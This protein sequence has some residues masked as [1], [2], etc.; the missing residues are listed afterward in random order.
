VVFEELVILKS[1]WGPDLYDMAA[2][3]AAQVELV[4][5]FDFADLLFEDV[6]CLAWD[7]ELEPAVIY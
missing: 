5:G 4:D 2:W 7:K 3:N 1:G 6:D